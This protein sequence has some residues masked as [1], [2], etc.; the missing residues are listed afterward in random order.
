MSDNIEIQSV[1]IPYY[2]LI[3]GKVYD[4]DKKIFVTKDTD[5]KYKKFLEQGNKP[6]SIGENGY[7]YNQLIHTVCEPY[8]FEVGECLLNFEQLKEKRLSQLE[9]I[10]GDFEKS[11]NKDMY[12]TSSLGFKSD[13]DRRTLTNIDKLIENFDKVA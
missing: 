2:L 10:S 13:G 1:V 3:D 11:T 7:T 4:K 9:S 5:E 12:F 6:L 8:H